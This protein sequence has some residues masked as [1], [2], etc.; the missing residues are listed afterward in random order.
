MHILKSILSF[1]IMIYNG[2]KLSLPVFTAAG[3]HFHTITINKLLEIR[4]N[5]F[6]KQLTHQPETFSFFP[7]SS[8]SHKLWNLIF[9]RKTAAD[10]VTTAW[11]HFVLSAVVKTMW[12]LSLSLS[13]LFTICYGAITKIGTRIK[14]LRPEVLNSESK[15][16]VWNWT[17]SENRS[18]DR[19]QQQIDRY[20][21]IEKV[22]M[23]L[24]RS[25]TFSESVLEDCSYK[26]W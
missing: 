26:V 11:W 19:V 22:L 9:N 25:T 7:L 21:L 13:S 23:Y 18:R 20:P 6:N 14:Y 3:S 4:G 1:I 5:R 2:E 15:S 16:E 8:S 24:T 17:P 12:Q 10:R